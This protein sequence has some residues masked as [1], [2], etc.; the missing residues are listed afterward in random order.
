MHSQ[1]GLSLSDSVIREALSLVGE[2]AQEV[3]EAG[4]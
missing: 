2:S 3:R 1:A 4:R